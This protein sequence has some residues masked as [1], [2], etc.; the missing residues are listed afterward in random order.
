[1]LVAASRRETSPD[2]TRS[3]TA[4]RCPRCNQ[5]L[6]Q[7][8][9][10]VRLTELKA[11]IFDLVRHSGR[12]GIAGDDLFAL[13]YNGN[14][15]AGKGIRSERDRKTLKSHI[16]QINELIEDGYRIVCS[17]RN[18]TS[19]Y[20]LQKTNTYDA[21]DDVHQSVLEG[22]RAIRRRK[23]AG[24]PGWPSNNR[25][26]PTHT[27]ELVE[28]HPNGRLELRRHGRTEWVDLD[29]VRNYWPDV[30]SQVEA[31]LAELL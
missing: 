15:P 29:H 31:A 16:G 1:V 6:P 26:I 23:A 7:M 24:G 20:R 11:R 12:D 4:L 28:V 13:V 2:E 22:F 9:V 8:R 27:G 25:I 18:P 3:M 19:T 5:V 30:L 14:V 10:G 17:G 21:A